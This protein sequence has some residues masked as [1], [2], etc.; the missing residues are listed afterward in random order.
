MN[1]EKRK[2][3]IP[4]LPY[5]FLGP[6]SVYSRASLNS[7]ELVVNDIIFDFYLSNDVGYF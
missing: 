4:V 1:M 5:E 2:I 6:T 3:I 7:D